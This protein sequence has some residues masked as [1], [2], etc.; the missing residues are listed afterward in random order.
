MSTQTIGLAY[1]EE[2]KLDEAKKEF[3]KYIKLA[4]NE[5]FGYAN[6]GLVYLRMGK[7][8][9]AEK[10]LFKAIEIDPN[11]ADIKLM[12]STVYQTIL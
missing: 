2:L 3:Q 4:P 1:L 6:L 12:L 10:Q 5:K 8:E 7:Y 11:D 9:D